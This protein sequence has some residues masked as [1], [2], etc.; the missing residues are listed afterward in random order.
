MATDDYAL[1]ARGSL[2]IKGAR[3]E[4][5]KKKKLAKSAVPETDFTGGS[6]LFEK[7]K[8]E[9]QEKSVTT[10]PIMTESQRRF[11][12]MQRKRVCDDLF[13]LNFFTVNTIRFR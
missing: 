12:E 3:V 11:E 4:K 8:Q 7:E 2:K 5:K 6:G 13:E 9:D 1:A 10:E